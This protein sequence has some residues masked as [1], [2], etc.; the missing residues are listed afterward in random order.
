M[1]EEQRLLV[2]A[3]RSGYAT[4]NLNPKL[5]RAVIDETLA[6]L[7]SLLESTD[8]LSERYGLKIEPVTVTVSA[9]TALP[10]TTSYDDAVSSADLSF[11]T[12]SELQAEARKIEERAGQMQGDAHTFKKFRFAAFDKKDFEK[13]LHDI[14]LLN[15]KLHETLDDQLLEGLTQDVG[16]LLISTVSMAKTVNE[17]RDLVR[18]EPSWL[19]TDLPIILSAA[20]K[21]VGLTAGGATRDDDTDRDELPRLLERMSNQ[22]AHQPLQFILEK[23]LE[24]FR[25][26]REHGFPRGA[27]KYDG[28]WY[29]VEWKGYGWA[30]PGEMRKKAENGILGLAQLLNVPKHQSFRTLDCFG[31]FDEN[32]QEQFKF[33]YRWPGQPDT[34]R[35]PKSLWEYMSSSYKPSLSARLQLARELARSVLLLHS[36]NWMHKALSSDNV[37]FFPQSDERSLENPFIVG[38]DYSRPADLDA[39]SQKLQKD[40]RIDI[41]R[42][43]KCLKGY[44]FQKC[45]DIYSLGLVLLDIAKWRPLRDSFIPLAREKYFKDV[46]EDMKKKTKKELE[47]IDLKLWDE[48]RVADVEYMRD[49]LLKTGRR[50]SHPDD[51]AFRAGFSYWNIVQT[52]IGPEFEKYGQ[53]QGDDGELQRKFFLQVLRPLENLK[54]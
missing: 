26:F 48:I 43:P 51:V 34:P 41:Y 32:K 19:R 21:S 18:A 49:E 20:L 42:N 37:V 22:A 38:F 24:S 53:A 13:L 46:S 40:A 23:R 36:A 11:L 1:W 54:V 16:L 39:P 12:S 33:L 3:R 2:W 10:A 6:E 27:V 45:Y 47:E 14:R 15:D 52:C 5:N 8:R 31:I 28:V 35:S 44:G 9:P 17:I 4:D 50:N 29:Y 7:K 30:V 25:L